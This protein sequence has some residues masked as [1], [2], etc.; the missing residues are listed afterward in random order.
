[1]GEEFFTAVQPMLSV[2]NGSMDIAST[3]CGKEGFFYKASLNPKFK[4]FYVN[5][6]DCPRHPKDFLE[7]QKL[8]LSKLEYA[9]E[10]LAIF[11]DDLRRF[12]S[13]E[14]L[15]NCC[16]GNRGDYISKSSRFY[17]GVDVA[18]LGKD[19]C[20]YEVLEVRPNGQIIQRESIIE[21]RNYTSDTTRRVIALDKTYHFTKIGVDDGGIGFG[22]FSELLDNEQT[23]RKVIALNN[24]SRDVDKDGT[25][26]K[27][28][29]GEEMYYNLLS[30]MENNKIQL[31]NDDE[32]KASLSSIQFETIINKKKRSETRIFGKNTHIAEGL[33]RAAWLAEKDKSL[34][35]F[36]RTF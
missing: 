7:Q 22:V 26:H 14:L 32:L 1:M 15:A 4:K 29:L 13:G 3:P 21:R 33:K 6:E 11:T 20:T 35:I 24:A 2:T 25:R 8:M 12:F 10:Y 28:L 17:L 31:L 19:D 36:V 18:G 30:M 23:R 5:A 9:Q 27:R 16:T 34:N